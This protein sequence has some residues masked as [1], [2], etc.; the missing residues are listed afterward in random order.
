MHMLQTLQH[1]ALNAIRADG[2]E[3][4]EMAVD[5]GASET[6]L[7]ESEGSRRGSNTR[8]PTGKA[9]PISARR[10]SRRGSEKELGGTSPHKC[11]QSNKDC[12]ALRELWAL[13]IGWYSNPKVA[14]SK[15]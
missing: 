15:M 4:V 9:F 2:W 10:S 14:T 12:S 7:K 8:L 5:S 11:V 6:S 3:E 13:G 1:A